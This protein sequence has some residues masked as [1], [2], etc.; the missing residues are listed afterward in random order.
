MNLVICNA[1]QLI[2]SALPCGNISPLGVTGA[3]VIDEARAT[4]YLDAAVMR[5]NGPHHEVYS[6]SLAD[7]SVGWTMALPSR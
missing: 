2:G 6:L 7:G 3:P 4:I 5:A 1:A